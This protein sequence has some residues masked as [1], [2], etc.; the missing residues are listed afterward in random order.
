MTEAAEKLDGLYTVSLE[1]FDDDRGSL[2]RIFDRD[3]W[4][5]VTQLNWHWSQVVTSYTRKAN[6]LRGMHYQTPP[7]EEAKLVLPQAGHMFW[8]SVDMRPES[9]TFG[10]WA[11]VTLNAAEGQALLAFPGFAHGC[12]SLS[13]DVNLLILSTQT[14]RPDDGGGFRWDDERIGI[15]WPKLDDPP[16]I[17]EDHARLPTFTTFVEKLERA[18]PIGEPADA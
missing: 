9:P 2:L 17:S 10:R 3:E 13:D 5:D 7:Y 6:T 16:Q 11:A 15:E 4:Q 14:H 8:A 18:A 1:R 12:L